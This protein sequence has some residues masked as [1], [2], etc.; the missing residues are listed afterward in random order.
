LKRRTGLFLILAALVPLAVASTAYACAALATLYLDK[1]GGPPGTVLNGD[2]RNYSSS[3]TASQVTIRLDSRNGQV[4][5]QGPAQN[6]RIQP[7][8]RIPR[9]RA[10]YHV[11]LATQYRAGADGSIRPQAGTPGRA[12]IKI[13]GRTTRGAVAAPW[14][15]AKP[16]QPGG[17]GGASPVV[18]SLPGPVTL[19]GVLLALALAGSG[20]LVLA[21][22]RSGGG[23]SP[24]APTGVS[25]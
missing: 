18:G 20:V 1:P 16:G 22:A 5:W 8:F 25:G 3:T 14:G 24:T 15:S 6:G 13:S 19:G 11:L 12:N 9:A 7:R 2:G 4:L 23:L 21:G 10:G 17:T